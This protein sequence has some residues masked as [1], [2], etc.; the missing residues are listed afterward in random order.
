MLRIFMELSELPPSTDKIQAGHLRC[1]KKAIERLQHLL[2]QDEALQDYDQIHSAKSILYAAIEQMG[3]RG[4]RIFTVQRMLREL[5]SI[6]N[7]Q[8]QSPGH[9]REIGV[10][11]LA[12]L[13]ARLP[14]I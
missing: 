1:L 2:T 4:E 13:K 5:L 7:T 11:I 3:M 10:Q 6:V 9:D 14:S 12:E 8:Y